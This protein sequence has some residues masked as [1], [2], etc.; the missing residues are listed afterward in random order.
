MS[1]LLDTNTV[2]EWVQPAPDA[3]VI[4]WLARVDEDDVF[5]SVVTLAELRY[6]MARLPPGARRTRLERWLAEELTV[7]FH[8]RILSVTDSVALAWGDI[9]AAREAAGRPIQAMDALIAA[10]AQIHDLDVVSRNT[11]DF[12]G[13]VRAVV[14]PWKRP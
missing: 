13:S 5:L 6:G 11:R 2:S 4:A 12:E 1:F 7:R 3:G 9:V 14:N 8:R 10:T